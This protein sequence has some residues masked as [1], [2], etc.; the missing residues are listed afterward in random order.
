MAAGTLQAFSFDFLDLISALLYSSTWTQHAAAIAADSSLQ[1]A[2]VSVLLDQCLPAAAAVV[3]AEQGQPPAGQHQCTDAAQMLNALACA[4]QH[5]HLAAA[6]ARRLQ[7]GGAESALEHAAA[8]LLALPTSRPS[9]EAGPVWSMRLATGSAL[10][11]IIGGSI[12]QLSSAD[13]QQ[14]GEA[15]ASQAARRAEAVASVRWQ[16][17]R[18]LPRLASS[19][20]ALA[21]NPQANTTFPAGTAS[22]LD[23]LN[24]VCYSLRNMLRQVYDLSLAQ[25]SARQ[26]ACWLETVAACLRLAPCLAQVIR[27]GQENGTA[28]LYSRLLDALN[29]GLPRQL[30]QLARMLQQL[31]HGSAA[32]A[33]PPDEAAAWE[34][35]PARLWA[36]HTGLCRFVAALSSAAAPLRPPGEQLSADEWLMLQWNLSA[37]LVLTVNLHRRQLHPSASDALHFVVEAPR[38]VRGIVACIVQLLACEHMLLCVVSLV[39]RHQP[40]KIA[41]PTL[42]QERGSPAASYVRWAC[43]SDAGGSRSS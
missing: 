21:N 3:A 38:Q 16:A 25:C 12:T 28:L 13:T 29:H 30:R 26:L 33:V 41:L 10:L 37:V 14:T 24:S 11:A 7:A 4:M 8:I 36:L 9:G 18:L 19:L 39:V 2:I 23:D 17:A 35:L 31:G 6:F 40:P 15:A 1:Q 43:G 32:A 22:W 27:L 20:A 5:E 34:G 42:L